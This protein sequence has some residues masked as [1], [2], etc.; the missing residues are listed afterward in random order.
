MDTARVVIRDVIIINRVTSHDSLPTL[1]DRTNRDV[2]RSEQAVSRLY[3]PSISFAEL[4]PQSR[5]E[6]RET[7]PSNV[8]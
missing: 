4:T 3:V 7:Y 1:Y 5:G 8:S 2:A 6:S